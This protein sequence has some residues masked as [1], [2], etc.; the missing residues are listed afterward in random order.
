MPPHS[1]VESDPFVDVRL[2]RRKRSRSISPRHLRKTSESYESNN[3]RNKCCSN[4]LAS[5]TSSSRSSSVSS[6][7][8]LLRSESNTSIVGTPS[9][10]T[11]AI[12][13]P[14]VVNFHEAPTFLQ[15]NPFIYR[16]YRTNLCIVTCIRR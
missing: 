5:S 10:T 15:F 11:V 16:G 6:E 14:V 7:L 2:R 3:N 8:R 9:P 4:K 12:P 13:Q 1:E